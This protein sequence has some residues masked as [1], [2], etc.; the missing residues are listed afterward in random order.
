[1]VNLNA[2]NTLAKL[3]AKEGIT[4][5]HGHYETAF[6]DVERRVLG[7]PVWEDMDNVYDLL[8]G[9]EVGHALFTPVEGWHDAE[10]EI[11]G[12]PRAFVNIVEDIRI[13]KLIQRKYP[14][15]VLSFKKGYEDLYARDFFKVGT[16]KTLR[17]FNYKFADRL[18]MKAKLR[19]FMQVEF[20]EQELPLVREAFAVE[21]WEDVLE[22]CKKMVEYAQ[23]EPKKE[24][25]DVGMP[26]PSA[27]GEN[28][29]DM[30]AGEQKNDKINSQP[31]TEGQPQAGSNES[32]Q[33]DQESEK[34]AKGAGSSEGNEAPDASDGVD[35]TSDSV[36]TQE[37]DDPFSAH[38]DSA[39]RAGVRN[40]VKKDKYGQTTHVIYGMTKQQWNDV[41]VPFE[42]VAA[43]RKDLLGH[44]GSW[45]QSEEEAWQVFESQNTRFTQVMA[46]EFEMKKAAWRNKRAQTARSGTL[47][48]NRLHSYKYND[49]IF[50]RI[51]N[52][53]DAKNHGLLMLIDWSGSM[54][55]DLGSVIK[56]LM[57]LVSFCRKVN[58]PFEVY[59]FTC[60]DDNE[61][62]MPSDLHV[63]HRDIKCVEMFSS[64]MNKS[65]FAEAFRHF[66][67]MAWT[68]NVKN[69]WQSNAVFT[70]HEQLG[71]TP[72]DHVLTYMPQLLKDFRAKNNLQKVNFVCMTDGCSGALDSPSYHG[73]GTCHVVIDGRML[74]KKKEQNNTEMLL[75]NL[76]NYCESS[77]GYFLTRGDRQA[78][79]WCHP[80]YVNTIGFEKDRKQFMKDK[81]LH[82]K[83][84]K[85]YTDYF[86]L[87]S[88]KRVLDTENEEFQVSK[89]AKKGE[90]SRAFKKFQ[91]SKKTNRVLATKF[92]EAV[93]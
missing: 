39:F 84:C 2:K 28:Y 56:Q 87:R 79:R 78:F 58:I 44:Y 76:Q 86:I 9:H 10:E 70:K 8:V 49:D 41:L 92:A 6:F 34:V 35:S 57:T 11:P 81:F 83:N 53:P 91:K 60:T 16:F 46:K 33:G 38:T 31:S 29:G 64:R 59:S 13:E 37:S 17:A 80:Q 54:W 62:V 26:K 66:H 12:I 48:T 36:T 77:V 21:T 15:L 55:N 82:F 23:Q 25:P 52:I 1:M 69:G 65:Q 43:A 24:M 75:E 19:D 18:N 42:E 5:Q 67:K 68:M 50:K 61:G 27:D 20:T 40:I 32:G 3:L 4:V 7:L 47:D 88:E 51:T 73:Y 30:Q 22:V 90:I 45:A 93:A 85:G 71:G 72:L 74:S 63:K 14:G 89:V